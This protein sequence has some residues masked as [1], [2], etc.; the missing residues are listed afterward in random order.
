M[1]DH[2]QLTQE[3]LTVAGVMLAL[4]IAPVVAAEILYRFRRLTGRDLA[5]RLTMC[6]RRRGGAK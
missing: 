1:I 6:C 5:T 3:T 2:I 4:A